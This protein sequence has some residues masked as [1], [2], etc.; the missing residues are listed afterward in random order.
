MFGTV[1]DNVL[2]Q[3]WSEARD[4]GEKVFR[5]GVDIDAH[6]VDATLHRLVQT[7]FEGGLVDVFLVLTHANAVGVNLDQFGEGV[8]QAAANGDGATHGDILVGE[9]VARH[10]RSGIDGGAVLT[11]HEGGDIE[12]QPFNELLGLAA[13]GAVAYRDG[14]NLMQQLSPTLTM[15]HSVHP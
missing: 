4:I 10:F 15:L 2:R 11:H 8:H 9:L 14:L 3:E 12:V 6:L 5:G 7:M 1:I 13:G